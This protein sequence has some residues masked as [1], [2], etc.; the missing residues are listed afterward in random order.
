[1]DGRLPC[2]CQ[3]QVSSRESVIHFQCVSTQQSSRC[4]DAD[5]LQLGITELSCVVP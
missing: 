2:K 5:V 1:M 3:H 4:L